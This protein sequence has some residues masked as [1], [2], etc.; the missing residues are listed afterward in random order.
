VEDT[1]FPIH[2]DARQLPFAEEFFDVIVSV[3]SY[4]YFGTDVHYLE[5]YLLK[6]L[7][8]GGQIGMVSPASPTEIPRPFPEHLDDTWY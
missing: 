1:V 5:F 6:L 3:D 7:K 4:H 2:A 8:Q